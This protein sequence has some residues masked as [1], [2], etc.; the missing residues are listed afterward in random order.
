MQKNVHSS[1]A[2]SRSRA[3]LR[4]RLRRVLAVWL[5]AAL[6]GRDIVS[7]ASVP[8]PREAFVTGGEPAPQPSA[9]G[10]RRHLVAAAPR[11]PIGG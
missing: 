9:A 7:L 6:F 8:H 5:T 11:D 4:L 10:R 3:A 1:R 2:G